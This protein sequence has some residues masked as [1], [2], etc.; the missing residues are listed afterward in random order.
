MEFLKTWRSSRKL[1][2][3]KRKIESIDFWVIKS[4][5]A[6]A[7]DFLEEE[8]QKTKSWDII[9][10]DL[11]YWIKNTKIFSI[12]ENEIL[13]IKIRGIEVNKNDKNNIMLYMSASF[14]GKEEKKLQSFVNF[15]SKNIRSILSSDM[16]DVYIVWDTIEDMF[17]IVEKFVNMMKLYIL[18]LE[19][20]YKYIETKSKMAKQIPF[21]KNIVWRSIS[22]SWLS[23]IVS[24]LGDKLYEK[25][26]FI[27]KTDTTVWLYRDWET[28]PFL[29]INMNYREDIDVRF[30]NISLEEAE[31]YYIKIQKELKNIDLY[32]KNNSKTSKIQDKTTIRL[33]NNLSS[34][35]W[36]EKKWITKTEEFLKD[37]KNVQQEKTRKKA[38]TLARKI[39][40]WTVQDHY[41]KKKQWTQTQSLEAK[42]E[43]SIPEWKEVVKIK[44]TTLEKIET[45]RKQTDELVEQLDK[46]GKTIEKRRR[47]IDKKIEWMPAKEKQKYYKTMKK[48]AELEIERIKQLEWL[49]KEYFEKAMKV[50]FRDWDDVLVSRIIWT[51]KSKIYMIVISPITEKQKKD[52]LLDIMDFIDQD[53]LNHRKLIKILNE[54][55]QLEFERVSNIKNKS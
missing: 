20:W 12:V 27:V 55:I 13:T 46:T 33:D 21:A 45:F 8:Y 3:Y 28:N 35:Q 10:K 1:N 37:K 26:I 14:F 5:I 51:L 9:S 34:P 19:R 32:I 23:T 49:E 30:S 31:H 38:R 2:N 22:E 42:I 44:K 40:L 25:G 24:V 48:I 7:Y 50:C 6:I 36:E 15:Y 17:F 16:E 41:N 47:Q 43:E 29:F 18:F 39:N 52:S 4:N 53:L 11:P 54:F